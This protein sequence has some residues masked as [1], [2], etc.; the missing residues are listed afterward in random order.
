MQTCLLGIITTGNEHIP[1]SPAGSTQVNVT[2]VVVSM[3]KKDPERWDGVKV[4]T[5]DKSKQ[6]GGVHSTVTPGSPNSNITDIPS[7]TSWHT[8]LIL[9]TSKISKQRRKRK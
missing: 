1:V 9:S 4:V 3:R 5:P 6:V 7:G 2:S 8:G